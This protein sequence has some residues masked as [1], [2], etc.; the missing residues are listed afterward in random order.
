MLVVLGSTDVY[1][2]HDLHA[3]TALA[4]SAGE[5]SLDELMRCVVDAGVWS[6]QVCVVDAVVDGGVCG[7]WRCVVDGGVWSME[8]CGR[9]K[10]GD[11]CYLLVLHA[12]CY[13]LVLHANIFRR[14][15]ASA[16]ADAHTTHLLACAR[17]CKWTRLSLSKRVRRCT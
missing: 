5:Q 6:M 7:R 12:K 1:T 2:L 14:P 17:F 9:W 4:I 11:G 15:I 3:S 8:V 13:L 16:D 10:C